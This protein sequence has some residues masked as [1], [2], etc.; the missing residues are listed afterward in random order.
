[1]KS[2]IAN[3]SSSD[4]QSLLNCIY[5]GC[6]MGMN[7][8]HRMTAETPCPQTKD[9]LLNL[10]HEHRRIMCLAAEQMRPFRTAPRDLSPWGQFMSDFCTRFI[11]G[12]C[13]PRRKI[14]GILEAGAK[15]GLKSIMHYLRRCPHAHR[16]SKQLAGELIRLER[17]T[18]KECYQLTE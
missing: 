16:S 18:L 17:R 7:A 9:L 1:M 12:S 13:H 6:Q 5:Q 3:P 15:Q 10:A 11:S 8:L 2:K 14:A 4:T